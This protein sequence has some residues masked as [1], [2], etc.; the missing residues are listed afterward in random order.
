MACLNDGT[1]GSNPTPTECD[2]DQPKRLRILVGTLEF[3]NGVMK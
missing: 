3:R 1:A 2:A